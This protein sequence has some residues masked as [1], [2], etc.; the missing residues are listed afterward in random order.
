MGKYEIEKI[1]CICVVIGVYVLCSMWL[2]KCMFVF[3]FVHVYSYICIY[4][5]LYVCK[6][7]V[8]IQTGF[9]STIVASK[10]S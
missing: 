8:L 4:V 5:Y 2:S 9:K 3:V 1:S 10:V 7:Y 6:M